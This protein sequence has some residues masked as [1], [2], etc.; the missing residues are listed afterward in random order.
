MPTGKL[1]FL[2]AAYSQQGRLSGID[3]IAFVKGKKG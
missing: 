3:Y 1:Y 2:L